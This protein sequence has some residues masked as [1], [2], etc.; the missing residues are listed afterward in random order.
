MEKNSNW[1]RNRNSV[2]ICY[3]TKLTNKR[4]CILLQITWLISM[5]RFCQPT[6]INHNKGTIIQINQTDAKIWKPLIHLCYP[7][8]MTS[9]L[10]LLRQ[11]PLQQGGNRQNQDQP[12]ITK[13]RS[14]PMGQ[15]RPAW[16]TKHT[17]SISFNF[18]LFQQN[19][20]KL[21]EKSKNFV[22]VSD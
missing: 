14:I 19:L 20:I 8:T 15:N 18:H 17:S 9:S 6:F 10:E 1:K 7:W 3:K 12:K 11:C 16:T 5:P 4:F 22:W 2:S 13:P 21:H